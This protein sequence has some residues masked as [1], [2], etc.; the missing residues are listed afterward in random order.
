MNLASG[1]SILARIGGATTTGDNAGAVVLRAGD[2]ALLAADGAISTLGANADAISI[3]SGSADLAFTDLR[4][5]GINSNGL[6]VVTPSGPPAPGRGSAPFRPRRS[7]RTNCKNFSQVRCA[8]LVHPSEGRHGSAAGPPVA[9]GGTSCIR[10]RVRP[11]RS[12]D[13]R[14]GRIRRPRN[15]AAE[16]WKGYRDTTVEG[17]FRPET[18]LL[19]VTVPK[20]PLSC[21]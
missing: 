16:R 14:Q 2:A 20:V 13:L 15:K 1:T 9:G 21:S 8:S 7:L 5:A 19:P 3:R 4:T 10:T 6:D 18:G 11:G 12:G 17:G